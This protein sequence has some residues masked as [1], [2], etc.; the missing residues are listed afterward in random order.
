MMGNGMQMNLS[1]SGKKK[2]KKTN[3]KQEKLTIA[4]ITDQYWPVISG[5]P[6]SID[7]FRKEMI[8]LGHDVYLLAPDYPGGDAIDRRMGNTKVIR[9]KSFPVFL[10]KSDRLVFPTEKRKIYQA[11]DSIKPDLIHLQS[12]FII[13]KIALNYSRERKIPS[14]MTAHTNWEELADLYFFICL[15]KFAKWYTKVRMRY[16]LNKVTT[17]IVPTTLMR[18]LL[19]GYGVT[20]KMH[21]VPTGLAITDFHKHLNT[22]KTSKTELLRDFPALLGKRILLS[23]GRIGKEKNLLFVIEAYRRLKNEFPNLLLVIVG[24][25]PYK[26]ELEKEVEEMGLSNDVLF[27]GFIPKSRMPDIYAISEILLFASKVE[28]QGLVTIEAMS[29]GTPVVAIGEMGT[30]EVMNGDNGGFMV[31]DDIDEFT[32]KAR[33]LLSNKKVYDRKVND[34]VKHS[35]LWTIDRFVASMQDL[36]YKTIADYSNRQDPSA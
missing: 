36:Y 2:I 29:C 5:V 17:V 32:G 18:S 4:Y 28:S 23:A 20:N 34:A 24:D 9:F 10:S 14:V 3:K 6:V 26:K 31:K 30:R 11:L 7:A 35:K 15:N 13:S 1:A 21:I 19:K 16:F 27:T 25:G 8:Q 12:E 22:I 33:L